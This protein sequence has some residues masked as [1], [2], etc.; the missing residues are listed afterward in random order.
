MHRYS[1]A[2]VVAALGLA[3]SVGSAFGLVMAP[4]QPAQMAYQTPVVVTGKVTAIE[5]DT[6]DATSPYAGAKDTQAYKVAVVKIADGLAGADN[7]THIKIGFIPPPK[8][9]PNVKPP[10]VGGGVRPLPIRR[11][12]QAPE[13][14]EGQEMLFFL[15]KHPT[16]DFYV[17][18][19]A[20]FP[21]DITADAGKK[22]LAEVKKVTT[23]L[24]DPMKGLKSDKAET[25]GE[26]ATYAL[27][28][29]RAYPVLGGQVE[30]VAI[31]AEESQLILKGLA[32][33]SWAAQVRF[34]AA[35]NAMTAFSQLG[36]TAKDGWKAPTLPKTPPGQ[37]P[38]DFGA[39]YKKA[40]AEWLAGPGK[41]YQIKKYV[42]KPAK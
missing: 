24:A 33:G 13:L 10:V 1:L 23:V 12:F 27:M 7:L 18:P 28:K 22:S 17:I 31:P 9:D 41:D 29:Y 37:P 34:D 4:P 38:A 8:V 16:A 39:L 42:P 20:N 40:F 19:G 14:K 26:A 30:Q 36:L 21:I 35:P 3:V 25:R 5:K 6:V 11:G 32:E 15:A 2:A